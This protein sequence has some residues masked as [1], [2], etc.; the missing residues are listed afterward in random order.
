M[1]AERYFE[2]AAQD[3]TFRRQQFGKLR[4]W[5]KFA[6]A[7]AWVCLGLGLGLTIVCGLHDGD[8]FGAVQWFFGTWFLTI[9]LDCW[10]YA[11]CRTA[12]AALQAMDEE[13][14]EAVKQIPA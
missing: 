1:K 11:H 3:A 8:W 6:L 9:V 5:R 14:P 4:Q 10:L 7:F 13:A 12:G 2:R